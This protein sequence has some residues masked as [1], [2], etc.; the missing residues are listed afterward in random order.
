MPYTPLRYPSVSK[1]NQYYA[2]I[3]TQEF[4]IPIEPIQTVQHSP[5]PANPVSSTP[6]YDAN[7][8]QHP[9]QASS[10]VN[11]P[12]PVL[13]NSNYMIFQ[14]ASSAPVASTSAPISPNHSLI[15]VQPPVSQGSVLVTTDPYILFPEF[16]AQQAYNSNNPSPFTV[17]PLANSKIPAPPPSMWDLDNYHLYSNNKC[18]EPK[19]LGAPYAGTRL[20][21]DALQRLTA[22]QIA[23]H[24]MRTMLSLR[25]ISDPTKTGFITPGIR[26]IYLT[27]LN[28]HKFHPTNVSEVYYTL[29]DGALYFLLE[30]QDK[31]HSLQLAEFVIK[32]VNNIE[33]IKSMMRASISGYLFDLKDEDQ[34]HLSKELSRE[35][36]DMFKL[37]PQWTQK[38]LMYSYDLFKE[39]YCTR[40]KF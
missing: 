5:V 19:F 38:L 20:P 4:A 17:T 29:F 6:F 11:Y 12:A 40:E 7:S 9:V 33:P 35:L 3:G 36:Y 39:C 21:L 2:P 37:A 8:I 16:S 34:V 14:S 25:Q 30:I 27:M 28:V 10:A 15:S 31:S 18:P 24:F 13:P 23:E 22:S 32:L 1:A 26:L